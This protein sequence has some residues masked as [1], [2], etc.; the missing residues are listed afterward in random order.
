MKI[1]GLFLAL[2]P[3]GTRGALPVWWQCRGESAGSC[4][5]DYIFSEP[6]FRCDPEKAPWSCQGL[7]GMQRCLPKTIAFALRL[8]LRSKECLPK[9]QCFL[10][11]G[12]GVQHSHCKTLRST[13]TQCNSGL[14]DG[15]LSSGLGTAFRHFAS[16]K[17]SDL[18]L[19][20]DHH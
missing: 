15:D 11:N 14:R 16:R 7:R 20:C 6:K 9:M 18:R 12:L 1:F 17:H 8:H 10:L 4:Y 3:T 2:L 5:N 13:N 19:R